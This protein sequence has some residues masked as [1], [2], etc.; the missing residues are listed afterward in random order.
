[1]FDSTHSVFTNAPEGDADVWRYMD[2][3]RYLLML[4]SQ[5]LHF[6]QADLMTDRWEGALTRRPAPE[7]GLPTGI[8]A[9]P[10]FGDVPIAFPQHMVRLNCWHLSEYES[11]A[12]WTLYER[13]GRG[14]A[15]RSTWSRLTE[16][17]T[18][19]RTI[20]GGAPPRRRRRLGIP[21]GFGCRFLRTEERL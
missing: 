2:L 5:A 19:R 8:P 18:D 4:Q 10:D 3:P 21:P 7:R 13:E 9:S 1:V 6:A 14:I 11:A 12:M 15:V 20:L 16:S 17:I